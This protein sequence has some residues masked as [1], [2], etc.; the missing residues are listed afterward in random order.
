MACDMKNRFQI[1]HPAA[2]SEIPAWLDGQVT[3]ERE[4][5]SAVRALNKSTSDSQAIST[6]IRLASAITGRVG[7]WARQTM[8][9]RFGCRLEFVN[10]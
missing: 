9:D 1:Q 10:S 5:W 2:S 6:M 4:Y 7:E 8:L 3:S